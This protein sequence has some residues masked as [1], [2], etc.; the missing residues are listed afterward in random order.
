MLAS[1][2]IF[3][4]FFFLLFHVSVCAEPLNADSLRP[5]LLRHGYN[6][7]EMAEL[8]VR[9]ND[10]VELPKHPVQDESPI[11]S[12]EPV[13]DELKELYNK[14][15]ATIFKN[16][17][18]SPAICLDCHFISDY[19]SNKVFFSVNSV[20]EIKKRYS[21]WRNI[22]TYIFAHETSHMV[23]YLACYPPFTSNKEIGLNG[24]TIPCKE[25]I[26]KSDTKAEATQYFLKFHSETE[27][28]AA[29]ALIRSGF[30]SWNSVFTYLEDEAKRYE[31]EPDGFVRA[32]D[33]LNRKRNIENLVKFLMNKPR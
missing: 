6:Y 25:H 5:E 31:L 24:L 14:T 21:D 16:E 19:R 17:I 8:L 7:K 11:P 32:A 22:L 28:Y 18:V 29:L 4:T 30:N 9:V 23:Q 1:K 33:F 12:K 13:E 15:R 26:F 20:N 10:L 3:F 27:V 2:N